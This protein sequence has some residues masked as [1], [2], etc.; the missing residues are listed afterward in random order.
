MVLVKKVVARR[1]FKANGSLR[2]LTRTTN[3]PSRKVPKVKPWMYRGREVVKQGRVDSKEEK[4]RRKGLGTIAVGWTRY[5]EKSTLNLEPRDLVVSRRGLCITACQ[6]D[7]ELT[8]GKTETG[9]EIINRGKTK[10]MGG[11]ER[12]NGRKKITS[13]G[14]G[15]KDRITKFLSVKREAP[16]GRTAKDPQGGSSKNIK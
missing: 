13:S 6:N 4:G 11:E 5:M 14:G 12:K 9:P 8:G 10:P 7:K 3:S 16:P 1:G 15:P 2:P